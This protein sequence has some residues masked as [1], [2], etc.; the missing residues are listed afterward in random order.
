M[1]AHFLLHTMGTSS[2]VTTGGMKRATAALASVSS[3]FASMSATTRSECEE[4]RQSVVERVN[5]LGSKSRE[6]QVS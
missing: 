2:R 5:S 3:S 1:G 4:A 6:A